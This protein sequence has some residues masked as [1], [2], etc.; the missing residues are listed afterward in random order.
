MI[1]NNR[2]ICVRGQCLQEQNQK[3]CLTWKKNIEYESL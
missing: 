1:S 2:L 3:K